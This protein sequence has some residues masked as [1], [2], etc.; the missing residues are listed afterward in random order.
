LGDTIEIQGIK[1]FIKIIIFYNQMVRLMIVWSYYKKTFRLAA[2]WVFKK[3]E[4]DNFY[5]N[6][7]E[8]NLKDLVATLSIIIAPQNS[9]GE[10]EILQYAHELLHDDKVTTLIRNTFVNSPNL[11][12]SEVGFGRRIGWYAAIRYL[13]PKVVVETGVSHGVGA[14]VICSA[15]ARNKS[16]GFVGNYFGTD[17]DKNAGQLLPTEYLDF[18][19]IL[20]GDSLKSL[21]SLN[22]S[23]DIFINDSDHS[24]LY[25]KNEYEVILN[26]LSEKALIIGDNSHVTDEL[27]NFSIINGRK[28]IF[29]Q[30]NPSNH[31][32]PGGGIGFSFK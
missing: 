28:Y 26:L 24:P 3:T 21:K 20:V 27:H 17:I 9:G 23:I 1:K 4:T 31:W 16:E 32:Y 12:D 30:E 19:E 25:E 29:F 8:K 18:A 10:Q 11:R 13:K 2:R 7:T 22:V 14:L 15:I 6:I 5:Y